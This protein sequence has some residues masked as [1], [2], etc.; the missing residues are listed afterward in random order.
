M[1]RALLFTGWLT[2]VALPNVAQEV[3]FRVEARFGVNLLFHHGIGNGKSQHYPGLRAFASVVVNGHH[4]GGWLTAYGGTLAFY[5][6]TLGNH[7]NPLV[8]DIQLDFA[9][10]F[11]LGWGHQRGPVKYLRT[12]NNVPAYN[13]VHDYRYG[14]FASTVFLFN[15]HHRNQS[16]GAFN[17]TLGDVSLNYY[18]DGGTPFD[19]LGLGD[20]FDRW[21]TGGGGLLV[22]TNRG[23]NRLELGF[24]QFTG[25]SP[26]AY[27]LSN[28]LGINIPTY[29]KPSD[30]AIQKGFTPSGY[31]SSTYNLR[32]FP[33]PN[34]GFDFGVL[35]SLVNESEGRHYGF[36]DIIHAIGKYPL[37]PNTDVN[38]LF[39]GVLHQQS[40]YGEAR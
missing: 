35:G 6:R 9:N 40:V 38:R 17:G 19:R 33:G 20:N 11:T 8:N 14:L 12:I 37:H 23:F 3:R 10:S 2:A 24:D 7:L 30:A 32:F 28:I 5:Q 34:F 13:L 21:W 29:V 16:I 39:F 26:L 18:N 36:Q 22:H 31:N 1:N 27:Q 25:Y 4:R 15:N